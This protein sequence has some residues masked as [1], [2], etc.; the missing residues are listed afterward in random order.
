[1]KRNVSI[2]IDEDLVS[3][4][5]HLARPAE[6]R[7]AAI[8]R[9]LRSAVEAAEE[10]ALMDQYARGYAEHPYTDDEEANLDAFQRLSA[11]GL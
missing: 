2:T 4:V 3:R 6:N 9:L 8:E 10:A 7:S 5:E 11:Q 1:M